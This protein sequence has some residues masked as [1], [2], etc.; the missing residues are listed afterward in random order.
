MNEVHNILEQRKKRLNSEITREKYWSNFK[1]FLCAYS[2]FIQLQASF[3]NA[4]EI[5]DRDMIVNLQCTETHKTRIRMKLDPNDIRSVP[6]SVLADGYYEPYQ[7]DLLVSLGKLSKHFLDIGSNMGFYS[8]ALASE[9]L[10]LQVD[11]FEPQ[12]LVFSMLEKNVDLNQLT[13][14][15]RIH[16]VGLGKDV[17]ILKMYVPK[18]T[19]TGGASFQNLHEDEG[20]ATEIEVEVV[21]L[22]QTISSTID[23]M[24]IDVEG[25]ELNVLHGAESLISAMKPTV[26][27]ELLRK[28]MKPFGHTPQ[29]FLEEMSK[30]GYLCFAIGERELIRT[31]EIDE[32]TAQT[33]FIYVHPEKIKHLELI[34]G[35]SQSR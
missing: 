9:N 27:V 21:V 12:P 15:V 23:L 28:W 30:Y 26:V 14:R 13:E 2:E 24:K 35:E 29:M 31:F 4:I 18:F 5:V 8:L 1:D 3:G 22:D 10:S 25:F 20:E 7:S 17:G 34:I 19:G 16:N 11:A 32:N 6:F 33:N